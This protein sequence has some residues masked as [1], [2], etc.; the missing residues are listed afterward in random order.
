MNHPYGEFYIVG[1][2][3]RHDNRSSTRVMRKHVNKG[4]HDGG[5]RG[6]MMGSACLKP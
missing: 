2:L 1:S 3:K 4:H 6:G 5:G